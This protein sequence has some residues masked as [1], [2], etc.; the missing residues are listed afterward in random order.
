MGSTGAKTGVQAAQMTKDD[1]HK[2]LDQIKEGTS[3]TPEQVIAALTLTGDLDV[4]HKTPVG[5]EE[6]QQAG[7]PIPEMRFMS[8]GE[9]SRGRDK[10]VGKKVVVCWLLGKKD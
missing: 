10:N 1:A 6:Q 7:A 9:T 3:A 4:F 8:L 5:T 2:L